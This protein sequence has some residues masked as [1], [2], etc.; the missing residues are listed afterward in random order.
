MLN[1]TFLSLFRFQSFFIIVCTVTRNPPES[2]QHTTRQARCDAPTTPPSRINEGGVIQGCDH[3][4]L[5]RIGDQL[6]SMTIKIPMPNMGS[7]FASG[8]NG[9]WQSDND[10]HHRREI[11]Q[12][13]NIVKL[14]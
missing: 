4:L 14:L 2:F 5:Q 11:I 8:L 3:Y 1:L 9:D 13:N 10:M 6:P 12:H 7:N